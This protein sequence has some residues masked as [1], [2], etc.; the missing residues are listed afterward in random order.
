MGY[1]PA[2]FTLDIHSKVKE[3]LTRW[4]DVILEECINLYVHASVDQ[5]CKPNTEIPRKYFLINKNYSASI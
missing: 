5:I 4:V 3:N 1:R 2:I